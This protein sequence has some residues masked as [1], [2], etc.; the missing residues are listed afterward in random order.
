MSKPIH[1][2]KQAYFLGIGG[3]G[4][5]AIC[6]YFISIGMEVFGYDKTQTP[7]T[8]A[9]ENEGAKITYED[10]ISS[11][12]QNIKNN[13]SETLFVF[14]PAIP[15][16]HEQFNW[17][18]NNGIPIFK[19]SEVLGIIS[20]SM[21][22][23]AVA[24][25]HGKT[26]TSSLIAHILY[27]ANVNFTAFLGGISTNLGT[28]Y[29]RKTDGINLLKQEIVVIEADEF[30]RSFHQLTPSS[31]IITAIDPDHLDI[32]ETQENFTL[33]FE[34]FTHLFKGEQPCVYIQEGV[35][36]EAS[37]AIEN[38]TYGLLNTSNY[39]IQD[40][41]IVNH[42]FFF[43]LAE[44]NTVLGNLKCGLPGFHNVSNAA[45]AASLCYHSLNLDF[46]TIAN[47]IESFKGVK[48]RFEIVYKSDEYSVI[49]DY[50]HHPEELN[51]II[52]SVKAQYPNTPI[53]GIFQPHLFSRTR[54]FANGFAEALSQLSEIILMEI[55]PARELPIPG[56]TST[57]LLS[58]M[59]HPN[60]SVQNTE[61]IL[62]KI[63]LQKPRVLLTLGAGD[64]DKIVPQIRT[65]YEQN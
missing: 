62:T 27:E 20:K 65:I 61:E 36:I 28:N 13:L 5:S 57:W 44:N 43:N 37:K 40:T 55:Y 17:L 41:Q 64:I 30:D 60:K 35:K 38:R 6:R 26:T 34:Q 14:T 63:K 42:Q 32:Y 9:L 47:G 16:D 49:D 11:I 31:G 24:G 33:A 19:R 1:A 15:K 22:C 52:S 50:A 8:V 29:I 58:L 4:M 45:A 46:Q 56:I 51:A 48:R 25:T 18:K 59:N 3:I 23:I 7:L 53:C 39:V 21:Y 54:D 10:S 12:P 2:Y